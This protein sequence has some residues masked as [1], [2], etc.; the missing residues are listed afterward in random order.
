MA[1]K[2]PNGQDPGQEIYDVPPSVE[3]NL[4][5]TVSA[6]GKLPAS[7]C[8]NDTQIFRGRKIIY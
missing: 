7:L 4:Q 1:V 6:T 2:G 8:K 3:K 5:Q